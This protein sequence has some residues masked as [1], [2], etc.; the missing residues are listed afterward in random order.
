LRKP[1][2][3]PPLTRNAPDNRL[4]PRAATQ[5]GRCH[6]GGQ[7]GARSA[8]RGRRGARGP[9]PIDR[10]MVIEETR[11]RRIGPTG[12]RD[13]FPDHSLR[14][15]RCRYPS[16]QIHSV[17][18]A[19]TCSGHARKPAGQLVPV[20]T[21]GSRVWGE[22]RAE[23]T[24][25]AATKPTRC[26][27]PQRCCGRHRGEPW[28]TNRGGGAPMSDMAV[29]PRSRTDPPPR[30]SAADAHDCIMVPIRP[31]QPNTSL[32]RGWPRQW[33]VPLGIVNPTA[34]ET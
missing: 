21:H 9:D 29:V 22:R 12:D 16:V 23:G 34:P 11:L 17:I 24:T 31:D 18:R 2:T 7:H 5:Q 10:S 33:R 13:S 8:A 3:P 25:V 19:K 32:W 4:D 26:P 28:K 20:D 15:H 27:I 6:A 30:S 14:R 1:P